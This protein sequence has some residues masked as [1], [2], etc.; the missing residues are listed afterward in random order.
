[1]SKAKAKTPRVF[2]PLTKVDEEQRL[3]YGTITE[4]ILDKSEEMMDYET[5]KPHFE[6]WS[7]DI[8]AASGGLSKG[9]LRV[10]HGLTV[11]GKL[12]ELEFN[13]EDKSIEV[14]SKVVD[15]GEWNKV[16]EGC[17]TGFS[18]GG[19]YG[20]K[21]NEVI[22]GN[23]IKKYT[24]IPNE[25]SLVDNPC[26]PS[27]TFSLVKADG[28][29]EQILFKA[30]AENQADP[31]DEDPEVPEAPEAPV[32]EPNEAAAVEPKNEDVAKRA[33]EMAKAANDGTT[34][35]DHIEAARND[36]MKVSTEEQSNEAS[37][38]DEGTEAEAES[39][40]EDSGE[41]GA[42]S[43][44][45]GS[46]TDGDVSKVT[47]P[48]VKQA[49]LASDG[50]TFDKKADAVSHEESLTKAAAEPTEADKLRARLEKATKPDNEDEEPELPLMEDFDRLGK[51]VSAILTPFEDGEPK[52]EKGMYTINRFSSILSDMASLSKSIKAEGQREGSDETD[53]SV[54]A[55]IISAVKTLGKSFISYASDQ[56]TELLAGMD[57]DVVVSYH[58]YY[59]NAVQ[60]D[61]ENG[62]AKD[63]CEVINTLRDD[64]T[65]ARETLAKAFGAI[66]GETLESDDE[67]SP[68]LKK[69]FEELEKDRDDFKKIAE[70]AVGQIETLTKR[71][72]E[73]A[74]QPLPR[75]PKDG[76]IAFKEGDVQ[77]LGK[78]FS[79]SEDLMN[80]V[81]DLIKQR[82]PDALALEL[83]KASQ[84]GGGQRLHLNR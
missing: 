43:D 69:R 10:M 74:E 67:L 13:D 27:A 77:F 25:V 75:A 7:G 19:K 24:A 15:D 16:L 72:D 59:Y 31:G 18:V 1:M 41:E 17:Y 4:E 83:I 29:E 66:I 38:A 54:S 37:D 65:E 26:V 22:D 73:I 32:E 28:A 70:D 60:V 35:I 78:S 57:D 51:V 58:D 48:G 56:V 52:L 14:C 62:L 40:A 71:V 6:K 8:H 34:W 84:S 49:W 68:P 36:L 21:W 82:G 64:A 30:A 53:S 2:V 39:A 63:V 55:D 20:K 76:S 80:E 5:S 44:A 47:P 81:H 23:T 45:T 12:T 3:V 50:Q 79:N 33:G 46:E 11:A 61:P 9:N 42:D